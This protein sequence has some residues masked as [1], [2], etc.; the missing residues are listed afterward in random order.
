MTDDEDEEPVDLELD[1]VEAAAT[2]AAKDPLED[3]MVIE[4]VAD[5]PSGSITILETPGALLVLKLL[6]IDACI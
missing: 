5:A 6:P 2:A 3:D 1:K 4:P